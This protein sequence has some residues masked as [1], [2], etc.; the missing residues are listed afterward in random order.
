MLIEGNQQQFLADNGHLIEQKTMLTCDR[1]Y[2]PNC[3]S[4]INWQRAR[5]TYMPDPFF[6]P[7]YFFPKNKSYIWLQM[8]A[9]S[10]KQTSIAFDKTSPS[11]VSGT[12]LGSFKL[13]VISC[14]PKDFYHDSPAAYLGEQ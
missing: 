3:I 4:I 10:I 2:S 5:Y 6:L 12:T 1:W 14:L 9:F 11:G 7:I 8:S 13:V